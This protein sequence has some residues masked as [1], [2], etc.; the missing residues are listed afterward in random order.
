MRLNHDCIR[1]ILLYVEENIT[2]DIESVDVENLISKFSSK[3]DKDTINYH[4]RQIGNASLVEE[5]FYSEDSPELI[6]DL[7]WEGHEYV[8]NI[9]DSKV[10]AKLKDLTKNLASVSLSVL[11]QKAPDIVNSLLP[12]S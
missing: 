6:S 8:N 5:V 4:I 10:W 9:R 7:T 2:Y 11:I 3:Y 12:K 1:D